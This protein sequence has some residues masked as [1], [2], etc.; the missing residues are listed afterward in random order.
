MSQRDVLE[1]RTSEV[2]I[3]QVP[4]EGHAERSAER[5]TERAVPMLDTP[6]QSER[7]ELLPLGESDAA[8]ISFAR[9]RDRVLQR[10]EHSAAVRRLR[11]ALSIGIWIW[12]GTIVLDLWVTQVTGEGNLPY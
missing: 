11:R 9:E 2:G 3:M 4:D 5:A 7:T 10:S 8:V 12:L 6:A 1:T